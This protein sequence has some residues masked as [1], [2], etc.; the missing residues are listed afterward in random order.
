[1][2][3]KSPVADTKPLISESDK[4]ASVSVPAA[5]SYVD[6]IFVPPT[7]KPLTMSSISSSVLP[8]ELI[9]SVPFASS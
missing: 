3:D 8:E 9:V 6:V 7:T 2:Y 1:M 5:S 4:P